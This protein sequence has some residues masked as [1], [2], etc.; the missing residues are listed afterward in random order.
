MTA[1]LTFPGGCKVWNERGEVAQEFGD[2]PLRAFRGRLVPIRD[3]AVVYAVYK[4]RWI[5]CQLTTMPKLT[6]SQRALGARVKKDLARM[7]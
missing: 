4:H 3:K 2:E 1:I 7:G 5:R 6:A